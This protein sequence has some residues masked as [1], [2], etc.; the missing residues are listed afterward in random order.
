MNLRSEPH[1]DGSKQDAAK[2]SYSVIVYQEAQELSDW[3]YDQ[4]RSIPLVVISPGRYGEPMVS[5]DLI[6]LRLGLIADVA[7]LE[8]HHAVGSL[9]KTKGF[10]VWGGAV[11]VAG[12]YALDKHL[13]TR[14]I[15]PQCLAKLS[16]EG[17]ILE[18]ERW[19]HVSLGK[20]RSLPAGVSRKPLHVEAQTVSDV[21]NTAQKNCRNLVFTASALR[22]SKDCPYFS[23]QHA[24]DALLSMNRAVTIMR[25]NPRTGW[26]EALGHLG[27]DY[28]NS[29]SEITLGRFR[30][31]YE[32]H[33]QRSRYVCAQHITLGSGRN[34]TVCM[35]IH[36]AQM[37]DGKL[38]VPHVGRHLRT[39]TGS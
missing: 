36:W 25:H 29:V 27:G 22:S 18:I 4:N 2:S 30:G 16:P 39:H 1:A 37:S 31:D 7:V 38:L 13:F 34:P 24:L 9:Q 19:V 20:M 32:F 11:L 14:T 12:P 15:S 35:S 21:V 6:A 17:R 33:Y 8:D 3:I 28:R 10:A 5:L 23:S 26:K